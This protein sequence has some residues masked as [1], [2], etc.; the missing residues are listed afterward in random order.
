EMGLG[1]GFTV[2]QYIEKIRAMSDREVQDNITNPDVNAASEKM[3][4]LAAE[5]T[6]SIKAGVTDKLLHQ[7]FDGVAGK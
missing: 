6:K 4:A 7:I 5:L 3:E 2:E 1:Q